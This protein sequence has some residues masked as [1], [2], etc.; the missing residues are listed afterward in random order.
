MKKLLI[1]ALVFIVSMSALSAHEG[2]IGISF[3]PEW[4]W[5]TT[6][7]GNKLPKN[8]E[9]LT[10]MLSIDGANYFGRRGDGFGL[11]YGIGMA[12]PVT[13]QDMNYPILNQINGSDI[14]LV[15]RFGI[16]YRFEFSRLFGLALGFG[17]NGAYQA[18]NIISSGKTATESVLLL[19]LHGKVTADL[20]IID[21]LRINLGIAVGGPIYNLISVENYSANLNI[22]GVFVSPFV[23]VSYVY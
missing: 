23:G 8:E 18:E 2:Q 13:Q 10:M 11:E 22:G 12:F 20:T 19:G 17:L 21:C 1:V 5:V 4:S 16:G 15:F 3:T 9:G 6:L 14:G 7:E